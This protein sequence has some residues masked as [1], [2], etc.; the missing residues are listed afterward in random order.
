MFK[1]PDK[2]SDQRGILVEYKFMDTHVLSMVFQFVVR[3]TRFKASSL[4]GCAN[5]LGEVYE[6]LQCGGS[7][8]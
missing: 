7:P 8:P 5:G 1:A 3:V 6:R 2:S 4:N